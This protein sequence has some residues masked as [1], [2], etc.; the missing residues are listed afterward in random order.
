MPSYPPSSRMLLQE[1]EDELTDRAQER[2]TAQPKIVYQQFISKS[3][4]K[5]IKQEV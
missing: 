4:P 5:V 3:S 2:D 1:S